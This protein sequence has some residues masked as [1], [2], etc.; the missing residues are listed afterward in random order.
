MAKK[1]YVF[2]R[3][4]ASFTHKIFEKGLNASAYVLLNI[5]ENGEDF[6]KELPSS[7]PGFYLIKA[8]F[9]VTGKKPIFKKQ[10]I[11]VNLH[12]LEKQG[13]IAKATKEKIY[14]LTD[15]GEEFTAY[16]K[17]RFSILKKPWDGKFRVVIFDVPEAKKHWREV[18]R[19]ELIL[20]QYQLLQ[21]SAYIGK[22]PLSKIFCKEL[23]EKG[24]AEYL[25]IFTI[26]QI[27]RKEEIL[28]L[29]ENIN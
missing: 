6:L 10:T 19:N 3:R 7:Y 27:D 23:E 1:D 9:G 20:M 29:F 28:K 15:K 2:Q 13:L 18:I 5:K 25:F 12:R 22:Y 21:K 4:K 17:N 11:R 26:D 8:M 24:I 16:I 14:F